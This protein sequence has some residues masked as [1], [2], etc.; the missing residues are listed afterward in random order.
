MN[1]VVVLPLRECK[2]PHL[3]DQIAGNY[4]DSKDKLDFIYYYQES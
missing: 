4:T 1:L 2:Q 3:L